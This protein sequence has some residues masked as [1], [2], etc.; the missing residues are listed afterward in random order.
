VGKTAAEL[1]QEIEQKRNELSHDV[2]VIEDRI[3]PGRI[4]ARKSASV[5]HGMQ[6]AK[7]AIMGTADEATTS[8]HE[9]VTNVRE[10]VGTA[11]SDVTEKLSHMKEE[12]GGAIGTATEKVGEAP[13][14]VR[15]QTQGNPV[16]VGLISFG[17]G[18]LVASLIPPSSREQRM[19]ENV[20]P[21]IEDASRKIV[22]LGQTAVQELR[23]DLEPEVRNVVDTLKQSATESAERVK[24]EA[25]Q[26]AQQVKEDAKEGLQEAKATTQ[27]A[28]P[29]TT[30]F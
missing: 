13:A 14:I 28:Q 12:A 21:H 15:R 8:V 25:K 18:L 16:A 27:T 20:Q 9:G 24:E 23:D 19:L 6:R 2:D 5:R 17:T 29:Q 7:E 26:S 30:S 3:R 22:D 11:A 10:S 4:V 1:R